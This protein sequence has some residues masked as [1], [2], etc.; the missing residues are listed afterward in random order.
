MSFLQYKRQMNIIQ[1]NVVYEMKSWSKAHDVDG[2]D[3][4]GSAEMEK[5][6][7]E[8]NKVLNQ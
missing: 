7:L 4:W 1:A 2:L 5:K 6:I 3:K 8:L